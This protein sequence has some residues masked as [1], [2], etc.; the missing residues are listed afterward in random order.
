MKNLLASHR[1]YD[2]YDEEVLFLC[3]NVRATIK[4]TPLIPS[5]SDKKTIIE[6]I[7]KY[8][9]SKDHFEFILVEAQRRRNVDECAKVPWVDRHLVDG[10]EDIYAWELNDAASEDDD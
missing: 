4:K 6:Y 10:Q 7:E 2:R 3:Y 8:V 1:N 9:D 5:K